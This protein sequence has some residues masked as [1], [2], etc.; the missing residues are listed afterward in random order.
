MAKKVEFYKKSLIKLFQALSKENIEKENQ[1]SDLRRSLFNNE[2]QRNPFQRE[3]NNITAKKRELFELN[4]SFRRNME[5]KDR[6]LSGHNY[7]LHEFEARRYESTINN[8]I[9]NK[10]KGNTTY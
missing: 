9:L 3:H 4:D 6:E 1:L 5:N 8:S 10:A 2:K 7:S